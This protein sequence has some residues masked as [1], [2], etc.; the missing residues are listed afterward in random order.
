MTSQVA[1][2]NQVGVALASDS[3][4]TIG[5]SRTYDS[6]N[7]ITPLPAPHQVAFMWSEG[8]S[9]PA[10]GL[11]WDRIVGRFVEQKLK[12]QKISLSK[13]ADAFIK[14]MKEDELMF[15]DQVNSVIVA[16]SLY[17]W[18]MN[19]PTVA[20]SQQILDTVDDNIHVLS[21]WK[22]TDD[23]P[24]SLPVKLSSR[25]I[26][27]IPNHLKYL[28]HHMGEILP[29]HHPTQ[30]QYHSL[31]ENLEQFHSSALEVVCKKFLEKWEMPEDGTNWS[32]LIK[33]ICVM[34]MSCFPDPR[35][36]F[37]RT[38]DRR[39]D[40]YHSPN[41]WL[42]MTTIA[43]VGFGSNDMAPEM[44]ELRAAAVIIPTTTNRASGM[45]GE[46]QP[47]RETVYNIRNQNIGEYSNSRKPH[48][49]LISHPQGRDERENNLSASAFIKPFAWNMEMDNILNGVH[50][51]TLR[52]IIEK[53]IAGQEPTFY[54]QKPRPGVVFDKV[55]EWINLRLDESNNGIG[56]KTILK[57]K[58]A[59]KSREVNYSELI[60]EYGVSEK[61][62]LNEHNLSDVIRYNIM[63]NRFFQKA[64]EYE[65][66]I[67]GSRENRRYG[68]RGVASL[69]PMKELTEFA[70][71]LVHIEKEICNWLQSVKSVGGH[72]D[73]AYITKED[74][75]RWVAN[76]E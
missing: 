25:A 57:I 15:D 63:G 64:E 35:Q 48:G 12:K 71:T 47:Y 70:R 18:L 13:Y 74:G 5:G 75:F 40:D 28:H 23:D 4:V 1:I 68:F 2:L 8:A 14:F 55:D 24:E 53:N 32:Q 26:E 58:E 29:M 38:R 27:E 65:E 52:Y 69:M 72:I 46:A 10:N 41:F 30:A 19:H 42:P 36:A 76:K 50:E 37:R 9:N 33:D 54:N 61:I 21:D 44:V 62:P 22:P 66:T 43:I 56:E 49:W 7:K 20:S 31:K 6:V 51:D 3:A 73:V 39:Q 67:L 59:L 17:D 45:K 60:Q 16:Q 11:P 34:Q